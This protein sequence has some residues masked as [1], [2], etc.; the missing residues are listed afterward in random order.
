MSGSQ[1][2]LLGGPFG[3]GATG[4]PNWQNVTLLSGTTTTNAGQNN[5]FIDSSSNAFTITRNGNTT[6]GSFSPFSQANGYWG[7]FFNGTTDYLTTSATQVIPTGDFTIE[8]FVFCTSSTNSQMIVSQASGTTSGRTGLYI[9]GGNYQGQ[10]GSGG[11]VGTST[12]PRLNQWDYVVLRRSGSTFELYV[13]GILAGSSTNSNTPENTILSIGRNANWINTYYWNGYISNLKISNTA[14][15]V[16]STPTSPLTSDGNTRILTC[17]SNRFVDNS[18]NAF[19]ITATGSPSVVPF[20]PFGAPTSPYSTTSIGGS[21]FFDGSGDYL[22]I[23]NNAAFA[24][25]TYV[26]LECWVYFNSLSNDRLIVGRQGMWI[27][28]SYAGIGSTSNNIGFGIYDGSNWYTASGTTT[29]KTNQWYHVVGV[30]DNTTLRIYINGVQEGTAS[31]VGSPA[32]FSTAFAIGASFDGTQPITGYLSGVR[33]CNGS[34][35]GALPYTGSSFTVP[36]SPPTNTTD[37]K[38]LANFTNANIYDQSAKNDMETVGNAQVSTSVFKYG[39]SSTYFDGT[40]DYLASNSPTDLYAFG[41]GE[42][43]IEFWVRFNSLPGVSGLYDSRPAATDGAYPTIYMDGAI[44][45]YYANSNDRI[46]GPTLVTNTWYHIAVNRSGSFTKMYVDG[47]QVGATYS[48]STNYLNPTGR[49]HIGA[50]STSAAYF[51]LDGYISD[52]RVTKG[53]GRYPYSFTPPTTSLPN[54]YQAAITPAAD[55][56]FEYTTLLLPGSGTNGAQNNTFLDS[57]SNTFSITRNGNTTQGTFSPFSAPTAT[58]W[59]NYFD[60]T[61]DHLQVGSASNWT[62]LSNPSQWTVEAWV[63]ITA[64]SSCILIDTFGGS[65]SNIGVA[66]N[67]GEGSISAQITR[68]V[69]SS[70][71]L[72]ALSFA[73]GPNQNGWAHVAITYDQ[74]LG[75]NNCKAY[76]NGFLTGQASKTAN[77]PSSSNPTYSLRIGDYNPPDGGSTSGFDGYISNLRIT[78][79]IVYTSNFTLP[80]APLTAITGT[81]LLTC[82]NNRFIDNST[83]AYTITPNGN[84]SVQDFSPFAPT[85]AYSAAT[86]GGSGYFD[87][88]GDYLDC[89]NGGTDYE[90]GSGDFTVEGWFYCLGKSERHQM[91]MAKGSPTTNNAYDWRLY[92]GDTGNNRI[93]FDSNVFSVSS[94]TTDA[95]QL[96]LNAWNHIAVVR[97]GANGYLYLNGTRIDSVAASGT[98]NNSYT[99]VYVG[100]GNVGSAGQTYYN[101][102]ANGIRLLKGTAQYTGSTY[103]VPTSPFTAIT[104]TELLLNFTNAGITD[105]T[106]KNV[107]ETNGGV[108]IS[109]A[110]AKFGS[111]SIAFDGGGSPQDALIMPMT[112]NFQLL[113]SDW[114][115]E[116]WIRANSWS[117]SDI[118][119]TWKSGGYSW[120]IQINGSNVT[121]YNTLSTT[122][123]FTFTFN[124]GQWYHVALS[125][126]GLSLR[127]FVDGNQVGSAQTI[128]VFTTS[129]RP[130]YIGYNEDNGGAGNGF[131]G[132]MQDVRITKGI[133]RY[134]QNFTPPTAAFQL[135]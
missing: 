132:Y 103:T 116:F 79:T 118:M 40:G 46:N 29:I 37:T 38:I 64:N 36:T 82:Q 15:T 16:G 58:S 94:D 4:D 50:L 57:S 90:F 12:K 25:N 65:S 47:S 98:M 13:N 59:S 91:I 26:S 95:E 6:Q 10:I 7:N 66:I 109:N 75:S 5:T 43:T 122:Y 128:T 105:A 71:V 77:A 63:Y 67:V 115:I 102:F 41:T 104:N 92:W 120:I 81:A 24:P 107:A 23:T 99:N 72:S 135:L 125:N 101:G 96:K 89:G 19:A 2:A 68:G 28:Y 87:Q 123:T 54:F 22:T 20:Q 3:A 39:T 93:W 60:G 51:P 53:L 31:F 35:S 18:A 11:D 76:V 8:V 86:N 44:L 121:M 84:A 129:T 97:S 126:Y 45:R 114:T 70:Y 74:S 80:T 27:S 124:T 61:G 78:N 110:Q 85:A 133:A 131:N 134:T 112:P 48:D 62:F 52:L 32:S 130:L 100:A 21:G 83:N 111:T 14:I 127:C 1:L 108:Q 88:N 33:Y 17:Q 73:T 106:A 30:R 119:G 34:T 56:Y 117:V 42:F 9:D 69:S 49:P 55:P 113:G